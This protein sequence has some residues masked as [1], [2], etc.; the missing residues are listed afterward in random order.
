MDP[1]DVQGWFDGYLERFAALGR[2]DRDDV[3][4]LL[5]YY[6]VPLLLATDRGALALTSGEDVVRAL[7]EQVTG[8]RAVD[9]D[10]SEL[11]EAH[12]EILNAV[13]A[14]YRAQV[15]RQRV[16]GSE[17]GRLRAMYLVTD[18][19]AGR[20]VSALVVHGTSP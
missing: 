9:Y 14:L 12:V 20:R 13:S 2:G 17:I 10:R 19:A 5:D 1:S 3:A 16:D 15:A 11:L 6:D 4:C 8:L 7:R 18:R